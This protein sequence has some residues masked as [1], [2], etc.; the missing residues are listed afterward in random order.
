[1]QLVG[2]T[3]SLT[4]QKIQLAA[5]GIGCG[6]CDAAYLR[7]A[8]SGSECPQCQRDMD[9]QAEQAQLHQQK[10]AET[11]TSK[12]RI[13]FT[14]VGAIV[15]AQFAFNMLTSFVAA[16]SGIENSSVVAIFAGLVLWV[17]TRGGNKLARILLFV[18]IGSS[19]LLEGVVVVRAVQNGSYLGAIHLLV[20]AT[21]NLVA[22]FLLCTRSVNVYLDDQRHPGQ[23]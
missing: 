13:G 15:L 1:M 19:V 11:I 17:L 22:L 16:F 21:A 12:G 18:S 8:I 4:G 2:R 10:K 5:S 14:A 23:D 20:L 7:S 6:T 3:C 9:V